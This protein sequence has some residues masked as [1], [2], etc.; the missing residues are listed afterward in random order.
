MPNHEIKVCSCC[1]KTFECK[2]GNVLE[3]QC[4]EIH[5]T[6]EERNAIELKYTDCLCID[7]LYILR[8]KFQQNKKL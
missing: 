1:L 3:C 8:Y 6:Y 7:C 4:N 5:L 2:V